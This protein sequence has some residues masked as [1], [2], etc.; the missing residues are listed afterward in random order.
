M[1]SDLAKGEIAWFEGSQLNVSVNCLDRHVSAGNGSRTALTFEADDGSNKS[2]SYTELLGETCRMGNL[3]RAHGV[4]KGD[5][6]TIYMPMVLDLAVACLACA[7]IGAIHNVIFGGFSAEAVA[8]R[9]T[10]CKCE[11]II[12][13]DAGIR[14]GK[15]V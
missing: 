7:R 14:G 10:D 5:V 13:T 8:Q 2:L 12:T 6:V 1:R 3:L 4:K 9:L 11:V 15:Q